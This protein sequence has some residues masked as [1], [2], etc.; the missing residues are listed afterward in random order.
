MK[1]VVMM[2][3]PV[4]CMYGIQSSSSYIALYAY[5]YVDEPNENYKRCEN[6]PNGI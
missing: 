6:M 4:L 3:A 5:V 1:Y 2:G